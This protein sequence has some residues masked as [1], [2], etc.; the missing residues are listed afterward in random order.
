MWTPQ[1]TKPGLTKMVA[2]LACLAWTAPAQ[3]QS[4][5]ERV[6]RLERLIQSG[7]LV[8]LADQMEMLRQEVQALRGEVEMQSRNLSQLKDQQRE[9]YLDLDRRLQRLEQGGT[10]ASAPGESAPQG[11]AAASGTVEEP[12][13]AGNTASSGTAA[14]SGSAASQPAEQVASAPPSGAEAAP[15][16]VGSASEQEAYAAAFELL[17]AGRFGEAIDALR[18]FLE[19][20]PRGEYADNARYWM[21]EAY[22]VRR[23]FEPALEEFRALVEQHPASAKLSHALLKIGYIHDELGQAGEA[24]RVLN[25]LISRF[26]DT[27]AARLARERLEQIRAQTG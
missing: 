10:A 9:L 26:P 14:Q 7:A 6:A 12:A 1:L 24:E 4:L 8:Q 27:T 11:T 25:D 23:E 19:R 16:D 20:Y 22:Y 15:T 2:A 13:A 21:G 5:D 3:S 17:K 18:G